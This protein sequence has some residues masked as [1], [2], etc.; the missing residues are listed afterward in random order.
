ME[1]EEEDDGESD[2]MVMASKAI[3]FLGV[4]WE[5]RM[6]EVGD[7]DLVLPAIHN[8]LATRASIAAASCVEEDGRLLDASPSSVS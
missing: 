1:R 3:F 5:N 6:E 2:R 7:R 4:G 8:W